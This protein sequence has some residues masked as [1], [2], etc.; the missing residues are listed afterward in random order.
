MLAVL[1]RFVFLLLFGEVI[2]SELAYK[3]NK[4]RNKYEIRLALPG[5]KRSVTV[6]NLS[7]KSLSRQRKLA[8][9][10]KFVIVFTFEKPFPRIS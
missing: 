5:S 9:N 10:T 1:L 2:R 7:K 8:T 6:S 3:K 4:V